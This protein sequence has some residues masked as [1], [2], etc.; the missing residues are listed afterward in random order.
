M[1]VIAGN[2][3]YLNQ[4]GTVKNGTAGE[5]FKGL[6]SANMEANRSLVAR[7]SGVHIPRT[8]TITSA[9]LTAW[10][11]SK[12]P[13]ATSTASVSV[14][15]QNSVS[16]APLREGV[17]EDA[18]RVWSTVWS[19]SISF[20]ANGGTAQPVIFTFTNL[21]VLQALVN[22][23]SW[24]NPNSIVMR[25]FC[26]SVTGDMSLSRIDAAGQTSY[27]TINYTAP[28]SPAITPMVNYADNGN[29]TL[30]QH[31]GTANTNKAHEWNYN[32]F[33]G[34]FTAEPTVALAASFGSVVAPYGGNVARLTASGT[35][36]MG[37]SHEPINIHYTGTVPGWYTAVCWVYVP[38]GSAPVKLYDSGRDVSSGLTVATNSW[39]RLQV[40]FLVSAEDN[41]PRFFIMSD[42]NYTSGQVLY[43]ANFAI[44]KGR[45][46]PEALNGAMT[47]TATHVYKY[48]GGY[49]HNG[50]VV[51]V[52]SGV[53]P[54]PTWVSLNNTTI[55]GGTTAE[56]NYVG[57][58]T[59]S[60]Y[61]FEWRIP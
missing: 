21:T 42:A 16:G 25:V 30:T 11:T 36:K 43:I 37:Y 41:L 39:S 19:G 2:L 1:V 46:A 58:G 10:M 7:Y 15:I 49:T 53:V 61:S 44:V 31:N 57:Q 45:Y 54:A 12:T 5:W 29:F 47:N 59:Q 40:R 33:F 55:R 6:E 32:A 34:T 13:D 56:W 24:T 28:A 26:T 27:T 23:A 9:S 20:N 51:E 17:F 35:S 3:L 60:A 14:Q 48:Q 38:T 18:D 8:S 52:T 50:S 22:S 4:F